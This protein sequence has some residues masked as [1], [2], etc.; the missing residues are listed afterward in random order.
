MVAAGVPGD[1][2][3]DCRLARLE[4]HLW[5]DPTLQQGH[6]EAGSEVGQ[7]AF[8]RRGGPAD[9]VEQPAFDRGDRILEACALLGEAL[10]GMTLGRRDMERIEI[11]SPETWNGGQHMRI[12]EI[13]L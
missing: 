10:E 6:G 3:G 7:D 2:A 4:H 13:G 1:E 5:V 8:Q 9:Q 11:W 12:R